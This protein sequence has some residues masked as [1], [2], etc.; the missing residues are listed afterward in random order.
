M[1]NVKHLSRIAI[2]T[3]AALF[4]VYPGILALAYSEGGL[5]VDTNVRANIGINGSAGDHEETSLG[6]TTSA[7]VR[8]SDREGNS[9]KSYGK[10]EAGATIR[11]LN[12][13]ERDRNS[14]ERGNAG[15]KDDKNDI[16][17]DIDHEAALEATTTIKD[18]A[19]VHTRGELRSFVNHL[20]K[21]DDRI[22]HVQVSTSTIDAQYSLPARF[23]WTI[24][25]HISA[26]VS[27]GADGSVA[28]S[29]P[30]YA[31]LFVTHGD[32]LKTQLSQAARSTVGAN[33]NASTTLTT[34][35]QAHLLNLIFSILKNE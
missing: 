32:E 4:A 21:E 11:L 30:W 33:A 26:Q 20:V 18:S 31:F 10:G 17:I 2:G 1:N 6:A 28:V 14:D 13:S 3:M 23:L 34:S 19:E 29:Y 16:E 35:T 27:V 7:G 9:E 24:P 25:T 22:A 12:G 8:T 5:N 15:T